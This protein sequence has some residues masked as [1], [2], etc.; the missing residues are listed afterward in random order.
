ML[1]IMKGLGSGVTPLPVLLGYSP[2]L[3]GQEDRRSEGGGQEDRLNE[4]AGN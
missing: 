2:D 3:G 4:G 1:N